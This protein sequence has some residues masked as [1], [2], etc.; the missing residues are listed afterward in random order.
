M[1]HP[2]GTAFVKFRRKEDALKCIHEA[3][4]EGENGIFLDNRRLGVMMAQGKAEVEQKQKLREQESKAA[5][6]SRNLY[7]AR[8]GMIREGTQA[9]DGVSPTDMAKRKQVEKAKKH[10]LKNL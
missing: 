3:S 10:L 7:L 8:E 1:G 9:A 2:R 5:K 6:D 4:P